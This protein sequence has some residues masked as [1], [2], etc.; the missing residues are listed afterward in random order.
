MWLSQ[1][2]IWEFIHHF[3]EE[4]YIYT[5][6]HYT[7]KLFIMSAIFGHVLSLSDS[8]TNYSW[9]RFHGPTRF[10]THTRV[11]YFIPREVTKEDSIGRAKDHNIFFHL[12]PHKR[13]L[14]F[15]GPPQD[16]IMPQVLLYASGSPLT[17]LSHNVLNSKFLGKK[18][19]EDHQWCQVP[20]D[21]S[22]CNF[23]CEK[24]S[25]CYCIPHRQKE[26][27]TTLLE[28]HGP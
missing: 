9:V 1:T 5:H 16:H 12:Q 27:C 3:P 18:E 21:T 17:M 6:T 26:R 8:Y 15:H 20:N 2:V 13:S 14:R 7:H 10:T 4:I 25:T 28:E 11:S 23:S 19:N 24:V 22:M